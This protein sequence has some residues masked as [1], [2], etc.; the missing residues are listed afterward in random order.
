MAEKQLTIL[1]RIVAQRRLDVAAAKAVLSEHSLKEA[2]LSGQFD[3]EYPIVNFHATLSR[4]GPMALI[5][6]I[7]R[8]SPSL[9][10][11][12]PGIDAPARALEYAHGGAVGISVLTEPTWFKG[13][14]ADMASIRKAVSVLGD[15]RPAILRKDFVIDDYQVYEARA[16]GADTL[17]LI[18]KVLTDDELRRLLTLSRT[19]G[20]EPLVEITDADEMRRALAAG[21]KVIGVNNRNLHDFKVDMT[22]TEAVAGLAPEDTILAALSGISVRADVVRYANVGAKAV[23]VGEA[24]MRAR[25]PGRFARYLLGTSAPSDTLVKVCGVRDVESARVA[26]LAG[27]DMI[28]LIFASSR[29]K[30][31]NVTAKA[32]VDAVASLRKAKVEPWKAPDASVV[33]GA[34]WHVTCADH[35]VRA[36]HYTGPLVVGV[37]SDQS[38]EEIDAV[39]RETGLISC[40]C[41]GLRRPTTCRSTCPG[42]QLYALCTWARAIPPRAS[43]RALHALLET[44]LSFSSTR[45]WARGCRAA[46]ALCLT[47]RSQGMLSSVRLAVRA[48]PSFLRAASRR[49]MLRGFWVPSMLPASTCRVVWRRMASRITP[50][51]ALLSK[52]SGITEIGTLC[53]CL[54]FSFCA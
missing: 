13:T 8:A 24:L 26:A 29:R 50:K 54:R 35:L 46:V 20:M 7:K 30:V 27:A 38:A 21:S 42:A 47:G 25:D 9:G 28:G 2:V 5:G 40:N 48:F 18:V 17:L 10:D 4:G 44:T 36:V 41:T 39:V 16:Y 43:R 1:E 3:A 52:R 37:F 12:C 23:L 53:V 32:I 19:L 45:R 31:D 14:L 22:R 51:F 11:I 34:A 33:C 15:K 49:T 6:E